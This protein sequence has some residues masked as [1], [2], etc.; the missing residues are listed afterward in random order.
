MIKTDLEQ[1]LENALRAI[2]MD[3]KER[4]YNVDIAQL[5]QV[6]DIINS[7]YKKPTREEYNKS[8][9]KNIRDFFDLSPEQIEINQYELLQDIRGTHLVFR[10]DSSES[11]GY[12]II[13]RAESNQ[14]NSTE[15]TS[16][17]ISLHFVEPYQTFQ[18]RVNHNVRPSVV[19]ILGIDNIKEFIE[20]LRTSGIEPEISDLK[21]LKKLDVLDNTHNFRP[22]NPK[23]IVG[24]VVKFIQ[25]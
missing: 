23:E 19:E 4:I 13:Y 9:S 24:A 21:Y 17:S 8:Y 1:T 12:S 18:I 2:G 7:A 3:L 15:I 6:Q 25:S 14:S 10:R 22:Y 16:E 11:K 5:S 20:A